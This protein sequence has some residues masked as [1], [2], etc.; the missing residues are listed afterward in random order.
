M[1]YTHVFNIDIVPLVLE[2]HCFVGHIHEY[3]GKLV[4]R[5]EKKAH[6]TIKTGPTT[7]MVA[8]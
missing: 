5:Y 3:S 8:L 7:D 6:P 4:E 2:E 1:F